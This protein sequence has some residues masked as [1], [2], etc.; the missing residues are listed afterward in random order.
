MCSNFRVLLTFIPRYLHSLS[1]P[2]TVD[3]REYRANRRRCTVA[4]SELCSGNENP[5]GFDDLITLAQKTLMRTFHDIHLVDDAIQETMIDVLRYSD[6]FQNAE[7]RLAY[8]LTAAR[9]QAIGLM[10]K[11]KRHRKALSQL[12][13]R[14]VSHLIMQKFYN[15]GLSLETLIRKSQRSCEEE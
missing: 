7:N 14:L 1:M 3:S 5:N 4:L 10:I 6:R 9:H 8:F 13:Y 2:K 12:P 15:G 11:D